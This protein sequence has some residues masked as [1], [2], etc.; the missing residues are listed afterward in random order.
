MMKDIA[1]DPRSERMLE[2]LSKGGSSRELAEKLGYQEGTMR[3]YLH[4]LY[5]KINVANK[6]EAVIW[7][8]KRAA[9]KGGTAPVAVVDSEAHAPDDLFGEMSLREGLYAALGVMNVFI[10]PYSRQ[11]EL[12]RRL[13]SGDEDDVEVRE[14]AQRARALFRA[15]LQGDW[16][17]GK[18]LYDADGGASLL[19]DAS[20]EAALLAALLALGGYTSAADRLQGQLTPRRKAAG[21][22]REVALIRALSRALNGQPGAV[23]EMQDLAS[24]RSTPAGFKQLVHVVLFHAHAA[25]KEFDR[26]RRAANVIWNEAESV[27]QQ[28]VAM[29]DRPLGAA[30]GGVSAPR[31]PAKRATT[32]REKAAVR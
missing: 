23:E 17:Y 27:K 1:L 20:A 9:D 29:G 16:A 31:A 15:L 21:S 7:W 14:R 11:W 6:T 26:A 8:M 22:H 5:K 2:L 18:R 3:V 4:H 30:R 25:L 28:L 32:T 13:D 24:E 19:V 12:A 10:G